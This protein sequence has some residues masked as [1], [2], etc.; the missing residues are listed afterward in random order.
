MKIGFTTNMVNR[1]KAVPHEAI[2]GTVP[3]TMVDERGYHAQ[4]AH[5][6]VTGE[7]FRAEPDLLAFIAD[8]AA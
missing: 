3:G 4:F 2:L 5:L 1:M 6:R 7:W 8:V